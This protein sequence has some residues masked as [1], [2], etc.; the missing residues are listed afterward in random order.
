MIDLLLLVSLSLPPQPRDVEASIGRYVP[1]VSGMMG[2]SG[3]ARATSGFADDHDARSTAFHAERAEQPIA[4][5]ND[6]FSWLAFARP[7]GDTGVWKIV[8]H[9]GEYT[10]IQSAEL[11]HGKKEERTL[12]ALIA[13]NAFMSSVSALMTQRCL[14]E[15][16]CHERNA[17][18]R[19]VLVERPMIG[20]VIEAVKIGATS[21]LLWRIHDANKNRKGV[22]LTVIAVTAFNTWNAIHDYRIY[23]KHGR[24]R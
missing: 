15:G 4:L 21:Y 2:V 16:T 9:A 11:G 13:T 10:P 7:S 24:N 3:V 1:R 23:A 5:P 18:M 6:D 12:H 14:G 22:W 17:V 8:N 20:T 19:E